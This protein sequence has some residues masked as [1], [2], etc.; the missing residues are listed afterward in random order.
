[1]LVGLPG[2][3]KSTVGEMVARS[4]GA[5]WI[6]LDAE[7]EARAGKSVPRIFAEDGETVFRTL[8]SLAGEAVLSSEPSVISVGG[9]FLEGDGRH[10]AQVAR[11]LV[12]YLET[13]PEVC[14]RRLGGPAGRPLLEGKPPVDRLRELLARREP[15]YLEAGGKV[16]TDHLTPSDVA[17]R[18]VRLA[19]ELGGW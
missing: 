3:G 6:E 9:G 15:G 18:V 10:L 2:S 7:I 16:T 19:R 17:G 4:L 13:S 8:E 12:V 11:A 14:A 1:V 5:R